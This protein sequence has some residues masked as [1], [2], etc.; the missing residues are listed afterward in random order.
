M[1]TK[2]KALLLSLCAVLLVA[3]TVLGTIAWLT[4]QDSVTNTF[5]V[6]N[7]KIDLKEPQTDKFGQYFYYKN[8]SDKYTDETKDGVLAGGVVTSNEWDDLV[9]VNTNSYTLRPGQ[10]YAKEPH[11]ILD[12]ASENC[13]YFVKIDNQLKDIE[14]GT[15]E[16]ED[17]DFYNTIEDQMKIF[18]WVPV[19]GYTGVYALHCVEEDISLDGTDYKLSLER[20]MVGTERDSST[21]G[22]LDNDKYVPVFTCFRVKDDVDGDTLKSLT[23]KTITITAYAV[24]A[25]GFDAVTDEGTNVV[26]DATLWATAF[27]TAAESTKIT[28][29]EPTEPT[30]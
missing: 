22:L 20:R 13:Y 25:D 18:G 21:G 10:E 24:Q 8:D 30:T 1:K 11:I 5:T 2:S 26:S 16:G 28:T 12:D 14:H 9:I 27:P 19:E 4:A 7:V 29:P 23:G 6:G 15:F 3:A 17:D